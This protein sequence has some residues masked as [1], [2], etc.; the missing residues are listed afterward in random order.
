MC[1]GR[2][3]ASLLLSQTADCWQRRRR[4]PASCTFVTLTAA[5]GVVKTVSTLQI[6]YDGDDTAVVGH[7][8]AL[9]CVTLFFVRPPFA[10]AL[11]VQEMWAFDQMHWQWGGCG[12]VCAGRQDFQLSAW[13]DH[14]SSSCYA[15]TRLLS[16]QHSRAFPLP[17]HFL[18]KP[19]DASPQCSS[20]CRQPG[21]YR[22]MVRS[23][24][25]NPNR[26]HMSDTICMFDEIM[27]PD[28]CAGQAGLWRGAC[29]SGGDGAWHALADS[30]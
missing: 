8:R 26:A 5:H 21:N 18:R 24:C 1:A 6:L 16:A 4:H 23:T 12:L 7:L 3:R 22:L 17:A 20:C 28:V 13:L 27:L 11:E 15:F 25:P 29:A 30:L 14:M 2:V 19:D 9:H 10:S